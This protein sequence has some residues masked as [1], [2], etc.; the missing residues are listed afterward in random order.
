MVTMKSTQA[1]VDCLK[2]I[3]KLKCKTD[4]KPGY[5]AAKTFLVV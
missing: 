3:L 2:E 5:L 4:P 1:D